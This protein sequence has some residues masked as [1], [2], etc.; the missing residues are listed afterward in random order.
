MENKDRG[1]SWEQVREAG[2]I[3]LELYQYRVL[4]CE[5]NTDFPWAVCLGLKVMHRFDSISQATDWV[6]RDMARENERMRKMEDLRKNAQR[7]ISEFLEEQK[8]S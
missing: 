6:Q 4:Y 7:E 2:A 5:S 1:L 3:G 8:Y